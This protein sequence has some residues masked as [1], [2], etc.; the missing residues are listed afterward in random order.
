MPVPGVGVAQVN[1]FEHISSDG[2]QVLLAGSRAGDPMSD[3]QRVG[4]ACTVRSNA[5]C[6]MVTWEPM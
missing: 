1:E 4:R 3:V 5:P 2:R 6:V